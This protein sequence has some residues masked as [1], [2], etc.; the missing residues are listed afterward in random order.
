MLALRLVTLTPDEVYSLTRESLL[1][2]G[3][4]LPLSEALLLLTVTADS[5]AHD[6]SGKMS[7]KTF[8]IHPVS[9]LGEYTVIKDIAEGTFGKVKSEISS[10]ICFRPSHALILFCG[11]QW[12]NIP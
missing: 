10:P 8:V 7:D 4:E 12:R 5:K 1:R 2:N 11:S 9:K 6:V 3:L